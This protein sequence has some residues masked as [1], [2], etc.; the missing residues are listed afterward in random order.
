MKFDNYYVYLVTI[1]DEYIGK[2]GWEYSYDENH[3]AILP[4][5]GNNIIVFTKDPAK[6]ME[7]LKDQAKTWHHM[8]PGYLI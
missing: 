6:M 4:T 3:H 8:A 2:D 7:Q 1:K 5:S